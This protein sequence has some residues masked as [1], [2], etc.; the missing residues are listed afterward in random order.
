LFEDAGR[1]VREDGRGKKPIPIEEIAEAPVDVELAIEA[2]E[3]LRALT[4]L[5]GRRRVL[6]LKASR[7]GYREIMRSWG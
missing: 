7:Y 2:R 5:Q 4:D 3:A 1:Q 6:A